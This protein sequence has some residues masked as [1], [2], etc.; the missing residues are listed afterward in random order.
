VAK[1]E[2]AALF[3]AAL[4]ARL[5]AA[6]YR[7][8][9]SVRF[10]DSLAYI[11]TA[12][13]LLREGTYPSNTDGFF[14]R[15]PGYPVF[16]A[17]ST[18]GH[19]EWIAL[20]KV[21]NAALGAA[22]V[23]ILA[24]IA[25][26]VFE[27]RAL[28]LAVG[29]LAAVHPPF[30]YFSSEVQSEP[31]YLLLALAAAFLLLVCVDR[32]SSGMGLVAGGTLA[33]AALVRPSTLALSPILAAPLFDRG[34][35]A[36]VRRAL[37]VS[38]FLGFGV[39]LAPWVARN[40]IALKALLPVN[41]EAGFTFY[42]GNSDWSVRFYRLRSPQEYARW[43]D[44][45]N[46]AM[47]TRWPAEIPGIA[48]PNPGRRSAALLEAS[49]RWIRGH[50]RE[51]AW[52]LWKKAEGWIRPGASPLAWGRTVV[53]LTTV[54][55]TSLFLSAGLGLATAQ[56]GGVALACLS[57]ALITM[58]V[59]VVFLVVLRYRMASWD[60]ILILYAPA[61]VLRAFSGVRR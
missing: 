32:P 39:V 55:Y 34:Y 2:T 9:S 38:A 6:A 52:L 53:V 54:Y 15:P 35:P 42:Q 61:G 57:I 18:A 59:H 30:L 31:L 51:E 4:V 12:R 13:R 20:D 16:L 19:P 14:F 43:I 29:V 41:D 60:P 3:F 11:G 50:P 36:R 1:R 47:R 22:A 25:R 17:L 58:A 21:W 5:A 37:A 23:V 28:A 49:F 45:M 8:F 24:A 7:G 48:D 40:A 56:R 33:L 44:E 10:G 27:S 26:R 46:L